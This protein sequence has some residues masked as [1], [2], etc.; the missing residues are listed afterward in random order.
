MTSSSENH[1]RP[2]G[3]SSGN[4]TI[5]INQKYNMPQ[6][7]SSSLSI[8]TLWRRFKT[9]TQNDEY[10]PSSFDI[11]MKQILTK[12]VCSSYFSF[13]LL[14]KFV[15]RD[16]KNHAKNTSD[17]PLSIHWTRFGRSRFTLGGFSD[18]VGLSWAPLGLS[19]VA[20]GT[21]LDTRGRILDASWTQLRHL[22]D[23]TWQKPRCY[24]LVGPRIGTKIRPSWL[25][26]PRKIDVE[27]T[28]WFYSVSF[29]FFHV[30]S[31]ISTSKQKWRFCKKLH[32]PQGKWRFFGIQG[33]LWK[34]NSE[35]SAF[36]KKSIWDPKNLPKLRPKSIKIDLKFNI[37]NYLVLSS[38]IVAGANERWVGGVHPTSKDGST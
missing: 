3:Q 37:K 14:L 19:W 33:F 28:N 18:A 4:G 12:Y 29:S 34:C 2:T 26:N 7:G 5:S 11:V 32:F 24:Q 1:A 16:S 6:T 27:K 23:A 9:Q 17:G 25:Q 20:R 36:P 38:K 13:M 30:L 21:L 35:L 31:S 15:A 10:E 8:T 22:L